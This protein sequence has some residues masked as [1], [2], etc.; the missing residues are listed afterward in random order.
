[1][2][3]MIKSTYHPSTGLATDSHYSYINPFDFSIHFYWAFDTNLILAH[4]QTTTN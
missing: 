2:Y 4:K 3:F 1:M